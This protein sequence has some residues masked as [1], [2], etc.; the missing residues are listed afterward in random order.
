MLLFL[1]LKI[2]TVMN[3]KFLFSVSKIAALFI[4][5]ALLHIACTPKK[6]HTSGDNKVYNDDSEIIMKTTEKSGKMPFDTTT[7]P[8][9]ILKNEPVY[10]MR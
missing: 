7:P 5:T 1:E 3:R 10:E 8:M 6:L 2:R 4:L 9:R